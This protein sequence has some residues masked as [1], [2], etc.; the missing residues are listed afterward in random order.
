MEELIAKTSYYAIDGEIIAERVA[1]VGRREYF[2]DALGS[3]TGTLANS[4]LQ[5]AYSYKPYGALLQKTGSG[6]DPSYAWVGTRGYRSSDRSGAQVYVRARTYSSSSCRW[7]S[8]DRY[9]PTLPA[10]RYSHNPVLFADP[11]GNCPRN[12]QFDLIRCHQ[13]DLEHADPFQPM[14]F[15]LLPKI[16]GP[17]YAPFPTAAGPRKRLSTCDKLRNDALDF[18]HRCLQSSDPSL[19]N[20]HCQNLLETY[21]RICEF[22]PQPAF[23]R[24]LEAPPIIAAPQP[25]IKGAQWSQDPRPCSPYSACVDMCNVFDPRPGA[26]QVPGFTAECYACCD[27]ILL[28]QD[29]QAIGACHSRCDG[30]DLHAGFPSGGLPCTCYTS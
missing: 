22:G 30:V 6:L 21:L 25:S 9:W 15:A 18:C 2:S 13:W 14:G 17:S 12:L 26:W 20:Q 29:S 19:C 27:A 23:L 7:N 28:G 24:R 1:S 11:S 8:T 4:A 10:H 3:V 16:T 5:N